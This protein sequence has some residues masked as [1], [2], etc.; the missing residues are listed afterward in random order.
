MARVLYWNIQQFGINKINNPSRKRQRGSSLSGQAA[1][2]NRRQYIMD[3]IV[4]HPPDILVIVETSTGGG[5]EGTLVT[6]GGSQGALDLLNRIRA[7]LGV[8]WMLVPPLILGV[9]GVSEGISVYYN[10]ANLN[11]SGPWGWQGGGNSSDSIANIGAPNL[12]TYAAPWNN[13]LPAVA[14]PG[15]NI[16]AGINSNRLAGQWL[17]TDNAMPPNR[18]QFPGVGNRPPYLTTFWEAANNRTIKLLSYHAPPNNVAAANGTN[19]LSNVREITNDL[20]ADEVGIIVGDF[21]VNIFNAYFEPIAY[22][23]LIS[24]LPAGAGYTR[25][26]NPTANNGWPDKGY[27]FTH[28]KTSNKAKPWFTNGYPGYEYVGSNPNFQGYNSIDN[29]LTRY[30]AAAGGPAANI[31]IINR[32]TGSPYNRVMPTPGGAPAGHYVYATNMS[33]IPIGAPNAGLPVALPLPPN[34][35]GGNGGIAPGTIGGL[36]QFKGWSNY[37]HI[38]STSDHLPLIIDI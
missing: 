17:F 20:N 31:T 19:Q 28:I 36:S 27:V 29:I 18:L 14:V 10:S 16:N 25:A 1:S 13:C 4:A 9:G 30:G 2:V 34:G 23:N 26:I 38:R 32:V 11:F 21:N 15:G 22:N 8:N 37:G 24:F 7:A 33:Q 6:A 12:A 3:T 5:A 35:P